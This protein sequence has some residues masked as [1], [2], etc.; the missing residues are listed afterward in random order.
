MRLRHE[1]YIKELM[2]IRKEKG[3]KEPLKTVSNYHDKKSKERGG[4]SN[5]PPSSQFL[6][7]SKSLKKEGNNA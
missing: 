2:L 4:G 7:R 3:S 6:K 5:R 1:S